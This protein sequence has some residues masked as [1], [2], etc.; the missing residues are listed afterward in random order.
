[1][2]RLTELLISRRANVNAEND[3][4]WTVSVLGHLQ[5]AHLKSRGG[6]GIFIEG[7]GNVIKRETECPQCLCVG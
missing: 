2:A 3:Y 7:G 1:M 4:G 6:W 5:H